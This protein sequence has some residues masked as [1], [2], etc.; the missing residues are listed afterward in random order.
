M[1]GF[2]PISID[3]YCHFVGNL[4]QGLVSSSPFLFFSEILTLFRVMFSKNLVSAFKNKNLNLSELKPSNLLLS[5]V[6]VSCYHSQISFL[7]YKVATQRTSFS[8]NLNKYFELP[9]TVSFPLEHK[10]LVKNLPYTF[11]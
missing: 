4:T 9:V 2:F 1:F 7:P 10:N 8:N 11:L 6:E 5:T 3:I